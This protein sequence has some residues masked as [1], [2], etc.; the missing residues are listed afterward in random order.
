MK[1]FDIN[2]GQIKRIVR[3]EVMRH[4][5]VNE[6]KIK[7]YMSQQLY[8]LDYTFLLDFINDFMKLGPVAQGDLLELLENPDAEW[9]EPET[10]DK[11]DNAVGGMNKGIDEAIVNWRKTHLR[12]DGKLRVPHKRKRF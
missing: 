9:I 4:K 6:S 1:D 7:D 12:K 5:R 3:S 11:I 2:I 8:E 10:I